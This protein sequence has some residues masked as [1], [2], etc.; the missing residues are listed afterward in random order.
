MTEVR[1]VEV[2]GENGIDIGFDRRDFKSISETYMK[3]GEILNLLIKHYDSEKF[4]KNKQV[5][6]DLNNHCLSTAK[7][8]N[9]LHL[10]VSESKVSDS[11]D[12]VKSLKITHTS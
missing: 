8:V 6:A 1:E 9:D 12:K 3:V 7:F 10:K 11:P 2:N 5:L 4:V